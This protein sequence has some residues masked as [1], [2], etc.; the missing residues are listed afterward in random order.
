MASVSGKIC[1]QG[2]KI[3]ENCVKVLALFSLI[4]ILILFC[5]SMIIGNELIFIVSTASNKEVL[6]N[7]SW[8]KN[9]CAS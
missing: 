2:G 3:A 8:D 5:L 4:P 7:L 1:I 6:L 9:R